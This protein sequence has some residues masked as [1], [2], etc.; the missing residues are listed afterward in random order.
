MVNLLSRG[1]GEKRT[2]GRGRDSEFEILSQRYYSFD[3]RVHLWHVWNTIPNDETQFLMMP[4]L[5]TAARKWLADY[6]VWLSQS[7]VCQ[8]GQCQVTGT[9]IC[10]MPVP[11]QR[12]HGW[13][14]DKDDSPFQAGHK[15]I[16][17]LHLPALVNL[18]WL[19]E[20]KIKVC[21]RFVPAVGYTD[22]FGQYVSLL[23]NVILDFTSLDCLIKN[24][25][26]TLMKPLSL[27]PLNVPS[28]LRRP[29]WWPIP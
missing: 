14:H 18:F 21:L 24:E 25:I 1:W 11:K 10:L 9:H 20:Y 29:N 7:L 4:S 16:G 28:V 5:Q 15:N 19:E 6:V 23:M 26:K 3:G 8:G 17:H 27:W 12:W 2:G 22:H 13:H